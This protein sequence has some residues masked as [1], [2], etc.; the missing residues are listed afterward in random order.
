MNTRTELRSLDGP[1]YVST[2]MCEHGDLV[3]V[4]CRRRIMHRQA[5]CDVQLVVPSGKTCIRLSDTCSCQNQRC[6]TSARNGA[7]NA[8]RMQRGCSF[9]KRHNNGRA[10]QRRTLRCDTPKLHCRVVRSKSF[11]WRFMACRETERSAWKVTRPSQ[12][13]RRFT[14]TYCVGTGCILSCVCI[15]YIVEMPFASW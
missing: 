7:P 6:V 12:R 9:T 1:Y 4:C 3:K 8:R 11:V 13:E 2:D 15:T 14:G 10:D 5:L